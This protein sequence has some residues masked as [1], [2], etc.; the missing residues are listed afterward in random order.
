MTEEN[1]KCPKCESPYAYSDGQLWNCP[2]CFHEWSLDANNEETEQEHQFLDVN[3]AP[4][5]NGDSVT[6]IRD[7]KAGKS[8]IKSG[9]KVKNIRLLDDPVNGHDISCKVDGHG[10][11]YLKCSVV[12]K[13]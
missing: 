2:E 6:V 4:L 7:L 11:M 8:T 5:Q 12:K 9:T 10:S 13:A 1:Q 3:G